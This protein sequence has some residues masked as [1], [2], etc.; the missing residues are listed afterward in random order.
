MKNQNSYKRGFTLIELLVVVLI[1]G[2]LASV[3][4]P[5][6]QKAVRK[7]RLAE[8]A[9]TFNAISK[10]IDMWQLENSDAMASFSGTSRNA[11]LDIQQ[12]CATEDESYCYT[13]LGGW[14][15]SCYSFANQ[16]RCEIMFL[17]EYKADGTN[18]NK[19]LDGDIILWAKIGE[20]NWALVEDY[21]SDVIRPEICRWWKSMGL[22]GHV[23]NYAGN[24]SS[25]CDAY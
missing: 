4:L 22:G 6:Y 7:A 23:I 13:K 5:Q 19:W 21:T 2:I 8:V 17:S 18:G 25:G 3:A 9:T 24:P 12:S 11:S 10:G 15:N 1:I 20:N 14:N 16:T